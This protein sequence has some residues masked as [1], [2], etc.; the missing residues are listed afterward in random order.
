MPK[1][2]SNFLRR[3]E[4]AWMDTTGISVHLAWHRALFH[5]DADDPESAL[6]QTN[7]RF[8]GQSGHGS[9]A[10]ECP[11]M[12]QSGHQVWPSLQRR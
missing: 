3:T 8:R 12:T 5:L 9:G 4:S 7:V 10:T 2:G 1:K 6:A 11:L